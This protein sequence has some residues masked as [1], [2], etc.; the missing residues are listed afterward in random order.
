MHADS[1]SVR[2]T[3]HLDD[4]SAGASSTSPAASSASTSTGS[5]RTLRSTERQSIVGARSGTVLDPKLVA[6]LLA[7]AARTDIAQRVLR[8]L[9]PVDTDAEAQLTRRAPGWDGRGYSELTNSGPRDEQAAALT[10]DL[11]RSYVFGAEAGCPGGDLL[12]NPAEPVEDATANHCGDHARQNT[13]D[14]S[15]K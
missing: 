12:A 8:I 10:A 15:W 5:A 4:A 6:E 2:S 14:P 11:S 1:T 9:E 3:G 7:V 13:S